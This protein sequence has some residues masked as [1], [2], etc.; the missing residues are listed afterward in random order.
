MFLLILLYLIFNNINM[1]LIFL[2]EVRFFVI[3]FYFF[4]TNIYIIC[5]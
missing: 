2:V 5:E 3:C 4:V 1:L